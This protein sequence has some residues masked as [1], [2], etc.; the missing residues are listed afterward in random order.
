MI[1]RYSI[2]LV[3]AA[4]DR[5]YADTL[6]RE[7]GAACGTSPFEPHV[8]VFTGDLTDLDA[9]REATAAAARQLSPLCLR[10]RGVGFSTEYFR[11][12]FIEFEEEPQLRR[13]HETLREALGDSGCLLAP[14]LSLLY[15]EMP[16][17]E[18]EALAR[19]VELERTVFRFDALEIVTPGNPALGWR[20]TAGWQTLFRVE[21]GDVPGRVP[22]RAVLFDFG[23]VLA[24]E[25]FRV[26][27]RAIALR[28]GLDPALVH[29]TGMEAVYDTGYVLGRGS[30]AEFWA[31]MRQRT[32]IRGEDA[33][34]SAEI[35][36][37]FVLRPRMLAAVR[38]LRE[39]GFVVAILSDQTDWLERLDAR[40]DFFR[41]FAR[42][43]NSYRL[44]K[45]KLDPGVFTE[46][47]AL[48]GV[49]PAETLFVDDLAGNVAR[50][51]GRGLR[52]LHGE[53]EEYLLRE[54]AR[55]CGV[56][57]A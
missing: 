10:A 4:A 13:L 23:G 29:R 47:A 54:L 2:F 18:A 36:D 48:L 46:V 6:M 27:L 1:P 28:Q 34:L 5:A 39:Q 12:L 32:G 56:A 52:T 20:D 45:G 57:V 11:T 25:G 38:A 24:E 8:T 49:Q 22:L 35:L 43:F 53:D 19:R 51:A 40:Y 9:L 26:G 37:R 14:H 50:A 3:P 31:A 7:I 21:L 15:R 41:E 44:G 33:E 55:Q 42:V 17:H 30:E 16:L